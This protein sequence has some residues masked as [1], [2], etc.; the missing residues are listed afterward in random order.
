MRLL[1]Q[2]ILNLNNQKIYL[3]TINND[4]NYSISF[5]N[6]GGYIKSILIPYKNKSKRED[7]LIGYNSFNDWKNDSEYFNCIIGRTSGRINK[8][9]FILNKKNYKLNANNG[10]HHLHGGKKGLNKKVWEIK[11]IDKDTSKVSCM[12]YYNSPHLEE[13]YPGN[14]KCYSTYSLNNKNEFIIK[15]KAISDR[16]TIINFTNHNYWNFHGHQKN[17][18]NI[19]NHKVMINSSKYCDVN[20]DLITSGKILNINNSKYNFKKFSTIEK[21]ILKDGGIDTC[22]KIS[23]YNNRLKFNASIYSEMTKM[24]IKMYSNQPGIQLYTGNMMRSSYKGKYGRKYG[25]HYGICLEPQ[26]FPN[27]I[28]HKNFISPIIKANKIYSS[29]IVIKLKNDF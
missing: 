24:G 27:A 13:G 17:Y 7:V 5:Y 23:K 6:Y 11:K 25:K 1:K 16:D 8:A 20:S 4:N 14:V 9:N 15:F 10:D 19:I 26:I 21:S 12:L 29:K 28:N 3:I 22:Y 2:K 18:K